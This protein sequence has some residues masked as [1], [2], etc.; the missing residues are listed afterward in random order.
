MTD[1][2]QN[3]PSHRRTPRAWTQ[4][5]AAPRARVRAVLPGGSALQPRAGRV[6][7]GAVPDVPTGELPHKA[8]G[9]HAVRL[10]CFRCFRVC[11]RVCAPRT[12]N[13]A[14]PSTPTRSPTP[15]CAF[16]SKSLAKATFLLT[17]TQLAALPCLQLEGDDA[18]ASGVAIGA[19]P[20]ITLVTA[21]DALAAAVARFGSEAALVAEVARRR[22]RALEKAAGSAQAGA[23]AG[24]GAG[25]AMC[26]AAGAPGAVT[27]PS[28][29][30]DGTCNF[31]HLNQTS[32]FFTHKGP[33]FGLHR[34]PPRSGDDDDDED[35]YDHFTATYGCG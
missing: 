25:G 26:A 34:C 30:K 28:G 24:A 19:H 35:E 27:T 32:G 12:S 7:G 14:L 31:P 29:G 23:G 16:F 5:H 21:R 9:R 2:S 11:F 22:E 1:A 4:V 8:G 15:Q 33:V 17:D 13:T 20:K 6:V 10:S 3:P 18:K